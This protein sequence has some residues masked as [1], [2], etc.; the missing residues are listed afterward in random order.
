VEPELGNPNAS[1]N[2]GTSQLIRSAGLLA[3]FRYSALRRF[4]NQRVSVGVDG[5]ML[6]EMATAVDLYAAEI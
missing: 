1:E 2:G 5:Y 4:T 3:N 6:A